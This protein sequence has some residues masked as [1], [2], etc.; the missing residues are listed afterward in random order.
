MNYAQI[1]GSYESQRVVLSSFVS[2]P[3]ANKVYITGA[4]R[5][6][7]RFQLAVD[8]EFS[9]NVLDVVTR[10]CGTDIKLS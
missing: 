4:N 3:L 8:S 5:I 2:T 9:E 1:I 6:G 7:D 10:G